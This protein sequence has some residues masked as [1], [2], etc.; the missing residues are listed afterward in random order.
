MYRSRFFTLLAF[1][2][3]SLA[4]SGCAS[5]EYAKPAPAQKYPIN[6]Q[7]S[8]DTLSKMS[9]LPPGV[10]HV[11]DSHV[12]FSGHQNDSGPGLG[13]MFGLI[14]ISASI[15]AA[16][17]HG[18]QMVKDAE[19]SLTIKLSKQLESAA[20][21]LITEQFSEEFAIAN[22]GNRSTLLVSTS[23]IFAFVN[24]TDVRPTIIL[25]ANILNQ[26]KK[27]IWENRYFYVSGEVRPLIGEN[28]WTINNAK[29]LKNAIENNM[30]IATKTLFT[31]ISRPYSRSKSNLV[32]VQGKFPYSDALLEIVGYKLDESNDSL[33]FLPRLADQSTY[34]GIMVLEKS[35]IKHDTATINDEVLKILAMPEIM[36]K[37]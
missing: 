16:S 3:V 25:K 14:G 37:K 15:M 19:K 34:A 12:F 31:D 33:I 29:N 8:Q 26:N 10:Y 13:R 18:A 28:S 4:L 1:L 11:P 30:L 21:E 5:F 36:T 22:S 20:K 27:S 6:F 35:S 2:L 24:A 9:S 23:L 17:D 32:K 7:T